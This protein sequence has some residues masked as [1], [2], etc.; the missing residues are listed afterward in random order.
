MNALRTLLEDHNHLVHVVDGST[1]M[2]EDL[3]VDFTRDRKRTGCMIAVQV[4]TAG[5]K[6]S[7]YRRANGYAIPVGSHADDWA[8]RPIPVV[9]VVYDMEVGRL[10]WVNLTKA[11]RTAVTPP[12]YVKVSAGAELSAQTVGQ[13]ISEIDAYAHV[14]GTPEEEPAPIPYSE[15]AVG[16]AKR[17]RLRLRADWK[18]TSFTGRAHHPGWAQGWFIVWDDYRLTLIHSVNGQGDCPGGGLDDP[19]TGGH[20]NSPRTRDFPTG[21]A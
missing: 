19:R 5:G 4:K 6:S 18:D 14:M 1:D 3:I 11:L 7:K 21:S 10:F 20:E 9:G 12:R 13:L 2:G 15:P 16:P 8:A 17:R